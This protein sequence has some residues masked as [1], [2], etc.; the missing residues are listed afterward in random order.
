MQ[1]PPRGREEE[2][3]SGCGCPRKRTRGRSRVGLGLTSTLDWY[4][5]I[6]DRY[7][8]YIYIERERDTPCTVLPRHNSTR[9]ERWRDGEI[10]GGE[11]KDM[12]M[13]MDMDSAV[14]PAIAGWLTT[15]HTTHHD[16]VLPFLSMKDTILQLQFLVARN[17]TRAHQPQPTSIIPHTQ[18][19][20]LIRR[21]GCGL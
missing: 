2:G 6:V 10:K 13:D 11:I 12:D 5:L 15:P 1:K 14:G 16:K 20:I 3:C 17:R 9:H 4:L 18:R 21:A 8:I 7:S 19:P